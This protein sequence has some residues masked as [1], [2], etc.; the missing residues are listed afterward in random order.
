[1][2][3]NL[4]SFGAGP[5][6]RS[7]NNPRVDLIELESSAYEKS[8]PEPLSGTLQQQMALSHAATSSIQK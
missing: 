7:A 4:T 8:P 6:E 2:A 1:M 3:T 5:L